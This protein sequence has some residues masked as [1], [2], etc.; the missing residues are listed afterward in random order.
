MKRSGFVNQILT[1][2]SKCIE[3]T[4]IWNKLKKTTKD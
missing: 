4:K 3:T 2:P 1:A